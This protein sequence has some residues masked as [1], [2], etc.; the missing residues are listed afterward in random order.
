ALFGVHAAN[1]AIVINTRPPKAGQYRI[2]L[3]LYSGIAVPPS[4]NTKN[5]MNLI[6]GD[7][8]KNFLMPFYEKY[9]T[10]AEKLNFPA[11][12]S[13]S[14]SSAYFGPSDWNKSYYRL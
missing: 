13:D 7:Y 12:L 2:G 3:N 5:G 8:E 10:D 9:A 1:G 14:T 6:N 4:L 11:Y